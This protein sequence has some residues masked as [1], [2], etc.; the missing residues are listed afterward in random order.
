MQRTIILMAALALAAC[1]VGERLA[2]PDKGL[3]ASQFGA[4]DAI[5]PAGGP[6]QAAVDAA[7]PNAVIHLSPGVYAQTVT[8]TSRVLSSW[9]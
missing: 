6:I 1:D 3:L 5:V 7:G 8:I 4:P 2:P 9:D